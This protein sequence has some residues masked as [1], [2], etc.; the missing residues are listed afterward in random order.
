[1]KLNGNGGSRDVVGSFNRDRFVRSMPEAKWNLTADWE[2]GNHGAAVV[3]YHVDSYTTSVLPLTSA[4]AMGFD[5]NIDSWR[6]IDASYNYNFN[7]GGT[8]GVLTLSDEITDEEAP[9]L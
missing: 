5:N 8:Q 7:I 6:T 2:R 1:M 4:A 3:L 9:R